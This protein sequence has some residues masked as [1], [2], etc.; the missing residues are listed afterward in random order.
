MPLGL[1]G[2]VYHMFANILCLLGEHEW[3]EVLDEFLTQMTDMILI[4]MLDFP[5]CKNNRTYMLPMNLSLQSCSVS[6]FMLIV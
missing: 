2:S 5:S 1:V 4:G 3:G 6:L